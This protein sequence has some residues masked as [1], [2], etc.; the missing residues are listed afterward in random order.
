[1]NF[2]VISLENISVYRGDL[3]ILRDVNLHI[4]PGE[5]CVMLGPNGAG[6]TTLLQII[7]GYLW[8]ST[9]RV[10]VLGRQFGQT[11]LNKLRRRI[12]LVSQANLKQ[13]SPFLKARQVIC[14]GA[15][16]T[17]A[18]IQNP[19]SAALSQT[20]Q[21]IEQFALE[22]VADSQF[23]LLSVGERQRVLIARSLMGSPDLLIL[24]EPAA[25]MDIAGREKLLA[26]IENLAA[27]KSHPT[28][29]MVTHHISEITPSFHSV[30]LLKD[31]AVLAAGPKTDILTEQ[32]ICRLYGLKVKLN[33]SH[34]RYWPEVLDEI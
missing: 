21:L 2:P 3:N 29:L 34:N 26:Y 11:D 19:D 13:L 20:Q 6:K 12:G 24:D 16:G 23:G 8:P 10:S 7:S 4:H 27:Q 1:M 25:G 9:G 15:T 28:L 30:L 14:T 17:L 33:R 18:L 5:H 22:K 32:N 31:G